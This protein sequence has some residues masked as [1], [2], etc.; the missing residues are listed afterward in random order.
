MVAACP[1]VEVLRQTPRLRLRLRPA[2]T[3]RG[4]AEAEA[5][6]DQRGQK[7][8][9]PWL[10]QPALLTSDPFSDTNTILRRNRLLS[11]SEKRAVFLVIPERLTVS[12]LLHTMGDQ[13]LNVHGSPSN[14]G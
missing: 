3:D 13:W 9:M 8:G 12:C 1:Q 4:P 10:T 11:R 2:T 6:S 5:Q 7:A 14:P